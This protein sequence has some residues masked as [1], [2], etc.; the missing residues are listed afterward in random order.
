MSRGGEAL[1]ALKGVIK[2]ENTHGWTICTVLPKACNIPV[3]KLAKIK[4]KFDLPRVP[5]VDINVNMTSPN[6]FNIPVLEGSFLGPILFPIYIILTD[7]TLPRCC[8]RLCLQT[9]LLVWPCSV[10]NVLVLIVNEELTSLVFRL[11]RVGIFPRSS[12]LGAGRWCSG[13]LGR[14]D[15]LG[16]GW[17]KRGQ[18]T[19]NLRGRWTIPITTGGC[20]V[21]RRGHKRNTKGCKGNS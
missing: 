3:W 7:C 19:S 14:V 6:V 11:A 17:G 5:I 13:N 16:E 10:V 8:H 4:K 21:S 2:Q 9:T 20:Q 12:L 18:F 1:L 15:Q